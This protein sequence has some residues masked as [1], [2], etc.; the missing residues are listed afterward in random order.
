VTDAGWDDDAR[1][2]DEV[3]PLIG[4]VL[5][6]RYRVEALLGKGAMGAVYRAKHVKVGRS[7]AV[8]VLHER[9]L[10]DPKLRKRFEREAELAGKLHHINV[11][12]VVDVG[13]TEDGIH[14]M[15]MEFA[16]GTTL[17]S[18]V[19]G[20][21]DPKRAIGIAQQLC[22]GLQHAHEHGLIHRDFKPENVIVEKDRFGNERPRIVDFGIAILR[23]DAEDPQKKDRLTTAGLVLGTPHYMA[24]EHAMGAGIDHRIDLF[25]LG[26]I[27]YEL[28][29]GWLPFDGDGVDVARANLIAPTPPMGVRVPG[30]I[31]DPLLEAFTRLLMQKKPADRPESAKAARHLLDLIERDRPMA[32]R[33]LG[34]VLPEPAVAVIATAP[35]AAM[36][37]AS[38]DDASTRG[39]E[40]RPVNPATPAPFRLTNA[41]TPS[42]RADTVPERGAPRAAPSSL[43]MGAIPSQSIE[44]VQRSRGTM[45][46]VFGGAIA[47]ALV[48]VIVATRSS[49]G[50]EDRPA[51]R[52]ATDPPPDAVTA[53]ML[54]ASVVADLAQIDA[55][56]APEGSATA[57]NDPPPAGSSQ[58]KTPVLPTPNKP[59]GTKPT[60]TKPTGT[61]PTGTKPTGTPTGTTKPPTTTARAADIS[62]GAVANLY[63]TVGRELKALDT[64][65]GADIAQPMWQRFRQ[66]RIN[67]ALQSPEK[68][69]AAERM[70]SQLRKD[71]AAAM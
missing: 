19:D 50:G 36:Q 42:T 5:G 56:L 67:D 31:V 9:L 34:V 10:V 21:M 17:G 61:K 39:R 29:T 4:R 2:D 63:G 70:L 23:D 48:I 69:A 60:G 65:R 14:F 37:P 24:P 57:P 43:S 66:L 35:T 33:I 11:I 53:Q 13:E 1:E 71:I 7:F 45:L 26:V 12:G 54:D 49:S 16:E 58:V 41:S 15:V 22:D 32:A 27:M 40:H 55:A 62:A 30:I 64:K 8:K 59:T 44:P 46:A 25:A 51:T 3:D 6:S 52:V 68:R 18:L 20:P 47:I 28:L 38:A